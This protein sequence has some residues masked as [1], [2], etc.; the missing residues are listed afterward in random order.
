MLIFWAVAHAAIAVADEATSLFDCHA[1]CTGQFKH[2]AGG[3]RGSQ[4]SEACQSAH[5]G[6]DWDVMASWCHWF[7]SG[8]G[9]FRLSLFGYDFEAD[10][11][12][13]LENGRID[14]AQPLESLVLT[15]PVDAD[16]H[17]GGKRFD[18][19]GWEYWV[20]RRWIEAKSPFEKGEIQ[21]LSRLEVQPSTIT[22]PAG[23]SAAP[24]HN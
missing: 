4:F 12:A 9:D 14:R 8:C 5:G 18:K 13:L 19:G 10:H 17:E 1:F 23:R 6:I 7:V 24:R 22:F 11:T 2:A 20:L 3:R 15:K 21:Q 16:M